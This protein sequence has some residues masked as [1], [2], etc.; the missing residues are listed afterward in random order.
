VADADVD[1]EITGAAID[2]KPQ[3]LAPDSSIWRRRSK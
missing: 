1:A 2:Q 3:E